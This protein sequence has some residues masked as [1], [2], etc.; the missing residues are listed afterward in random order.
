[1]QGRCVQRTRHI[2]LGEHFIDIF[3]MQKTTYQYRRTFKKE[4]KSI[5]S[6]SNAIGTLMTFQ[7]FEI[8]YFVQSIGGLH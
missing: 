3:S 4:T 2:L 7:F 6:E 8:W 1:M 5:I